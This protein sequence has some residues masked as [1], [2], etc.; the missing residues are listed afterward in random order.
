MLSAAATSLYEGLPVSGIEAQT[1]G[2]PC[3][4]ADT[5]TKEVGILTDRVQFLSIRQPAKIWAERIAEQKTCVVDRNIDNE[6]LLGD[7]NIKNNAE[8]LCKFFISV[9]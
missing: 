7:Y 4:Y 5:I 3:I 2:L 9:L 1:S 6:I 8:K